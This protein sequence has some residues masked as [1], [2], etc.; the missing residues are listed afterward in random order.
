[1]EEPRAAEEQNNML[2]GSE[3]SDKQASGT[4]S[5]PRG[6]WL[7][8]AI[9][10]VVLVQVVY[11]ALVFGLLG[12]Q[13]AVRGQF[14]DIFGGVN[15]LFTGLAFAGVIYT[16]LLQRRELELQREELRLNRV[17]LS[18]SAQA[19]ADQVEM[20]K[21]SAGLSAMS[22]LVDVYGTLLRP[23]WDNAREIQAEIGRL[24][25]EQMSQ[26]GII[27]YENAARISH[28]GSEARAMQQEW[29]QTLQAH[30]ALMRRLERMVE[31]SD[32]SGSTSSEEPGNEP[33]RAH[34]GAEPEE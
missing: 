14:G 31:E 34:T 2:G 19:Q 21:Q 8:V 17:E 10:G 4:P 16:I 13:M 27:T 1:M 7:I 32:H 3:A 18:R 23:Y 20:L 6:L 28:L 11:G 24:E 5:G 25:R 22:S 29:R 12:P 30:Q 9:C 26:A 15:A 33:G